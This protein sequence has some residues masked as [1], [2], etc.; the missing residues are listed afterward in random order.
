MNTEFPRSV[1]RNWWVLLIR[2][3]CGIL[4]GFL[5][6]TW[7]HITLFVLALMFGAYVGA[8]GLL[9]IAAAMRG[10]TQEPRWWLALAGIVAVLARLATFLAPGI[11]ALMLLYVIS[12]WAIIH[13]MIEIIGAIQLRKFIDHEWLLILSGTIS[14]LFGLFVLIWPG[15]GALSLIV[16]I[17]I[18][19][20]AGGLLWIAL[21]LKLQR[22]HRL[23][24]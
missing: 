11:T 1:Y 2:G 16:L 5:A 15:A 10:N 7:P 12:V 20:I 19:A 6:I 17:G 13:G 3:L 9:E 24:L 23:N 14:V 18:Y 21:S 4:F 22:R 8:A